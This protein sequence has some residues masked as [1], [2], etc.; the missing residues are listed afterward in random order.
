MKLKRTLEHNTSIF[1][2]P[3]NVHILTEGKHFIFNNINILYPNHNTAVT[4]VD[5]KKIHSSVVDLSLAFHYYY[6]LFIV[7][8]L[9][10]A[11]CHIVIQFP[12]NYCDT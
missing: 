4:I 7:Y 10:T 11:F 6:K 12:N 8:I 3:T 5:F 2:S 9:H 1:S